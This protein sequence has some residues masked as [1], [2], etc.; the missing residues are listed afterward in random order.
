[1]FIAYTLTFYVLAAIAYLVIACLLMEDATDKR[2]E[3][4]AAVGILLT[5]VWPV[6]VVIGVIYIIALVF[7][8]AVKTLFGK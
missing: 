4:A 3:K 6:P 5:P 2:E 1:M 7:T 8:G